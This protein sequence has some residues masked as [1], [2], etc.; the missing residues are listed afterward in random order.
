M[1]KVTHLIAAVLLASTVPL[2]AQV[3]TQGSILGTV[4]DSSGA[5][6]PGATITVTGL[7]TGLVQTATSDHTGSFEILALPIG[8][9]SVAVT[10]Q[11][12]KTWQLERVVLTV[13]ER[14]KITPVLEV[15]NISE[16]VSV[17]GGAPLL[18]T[19]RSS[20]QTVVEMQQIRELP[21]STRNPVVLVN[22]APGMRF[23]G[24]G[25]PERGSTVQGFGL[26]SN[27][28]EFQLDGLNANASMD[29][30]AITIPNVDTIA[31]FSVETSSFSA[32]NG[33]NPLQVVMATKSGTNSF[34]GTVWEFNQNDRFSARNAFST[35][36]PPKLNRN[37]YGAAIGGP[38]LR[39]RTF[40]FGSFEGTPID[41]DDL[42]NSV[43]PQAAM[44][45]GDFSSLGHAIIDPT[46]GQ[47]FPG[48]RIPAHRISSASQFFFPYLLTPNDPDGGF[49][50]V[51]PVTDDTYQYTA[52]LDHQFTASQR[53]YG[54][55]VMNKNPTDSPGY[56]P[57][58]RSA[59]K[60][61]QHNIGVNYTNSLSSTL[62]LTVTGGYLKSDNRFT[63]P[64]YCALKSKLPRG[65][66][67]P[68][69][70]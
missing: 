4:M 70:P 49:H 11:G 33:R 38:V 14:K 42:Y 26:R 67:E 27:Q 16:Q 50:A 61:T 25:G 18:Q 45:Q 60:T 9:Y 68:C 59:N 6:L 24:S 47:P 46:T 41:T 57:D 31:E 54:R 23:T 40:F 21:L 39:N 34:H 1:S 20:V 66:C 52:R 44:L 15:G 2:A 19:E 10:V 56:S 30:G 62:L 29:E 32:E 17:V 64:V 35:S 55:W 28:T 63:S 12:F 13:G 43:V 69:R 65:E 53:I 58:V 36:D 51:A 3:G 48:N 8:P 22:L 37:Q 7:D 5:A